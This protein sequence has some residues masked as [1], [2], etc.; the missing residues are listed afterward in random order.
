MPKLT[1]RL[2]DSLRP[3]DDDQF[4]WDDELAGF[5]VRVRPSGRRSFVVQYRTPER[6]QRRR[7]IGT[8]PTMTVDQARRAA[9]EWLVDAQK[10]EDPAEA[11]DISRQ[12]ETVS[13]LC[14]RFLAHHAALHKKPQSAREDRRIIE[15]YIKPAMG[16]R[17]AASV[18]QKDVES[19]HKSLK[20]A[21]Y[22]A[23]R[24]LALLSTIFNMAEPELR[25]SRSDWVNPCRWVKR[26][27]E[28]KRRRYLSS[29]ELA[30]LGQALAT[31]E[32]E[33]SEW[34]WA[35]AAIRLLIFTGC[36][37][38]EILTL[39][40]DEVDFEAHRLRLAD[41]KTG[42]KDIYLGPPALEVLENLQRVDGNLS[43]PN[44]RS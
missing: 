32:T 3:A 6:R 17:F 43:L 14:E 21:P 40:W 25:R 33:R 22:Q 38:S 34:P 12:A 8:Y 26:F 16:R 37:R 24:V 2:I 28:E 29:A 27:A 35:I 19:L 39:R 20:T 23:N 13:D 30:R 11:Q 1:K 10:G 7:V 31:A 18:T 4:A 9:R 5:C 36:R 44:I 15:R 42:A 41:S